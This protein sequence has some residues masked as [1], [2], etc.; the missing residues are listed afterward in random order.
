MQVH[1]NSPFP[2]S[3]EFGLQQVNLSRAP[4]L[5]AVKLWRRW[6]V[7]HLDVLFRDKIN[8]TLN[9]DDT[10]QPL[11]PAEAVTFMSMLEALTEL[12]F[13]LPLFAQCGVCF[14]KPV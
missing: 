1:T 2:L 14:D 4:P 9:D 7:E 13:K 5:L 11:E 6:G 10:V 8:K 3:L 12:C